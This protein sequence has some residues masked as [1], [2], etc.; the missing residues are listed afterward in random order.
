MDVTF[1]DSQMVSETSCPDQKL[2]HEIPNVNILCKK[3]F[4]PLR[5]I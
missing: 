1:N 4:G 2:Y 3:S 5:V